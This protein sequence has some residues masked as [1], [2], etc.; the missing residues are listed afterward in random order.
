MKKVLCVCLA[1]V[2]LLGAIFIAPTTTRAASNMK[3]SEDCIAVIKELEG[4]RG[5]PYTDTDGLYTIGYGTR[6]PADKVDQYMQTPMTEA[7]ADLALREKLLSYESAVNKF[8]DRHGLTY[9][10][11]Q[12]DAVISLVFNCGTA[13]LTKGE[14]LVAALTSGA[15]GND[16]IYAFSIYSTSGG[17]R[18]VGH[19]KRRLAESNMYLNGQY[20]RTPP[21]NYSY[22]IYD[23]N[24][25]EVS[26][27]N[28]QGY[29]INTPVAVIPTATYAGY[30]FRGWYTARNGGTKVTVLDASTKAATL[31]AQWEK[32]DG[33]AA[34]PVDPKPSQP[35]EPTVPSGTAITPVEV[36]VTGSEVNIRKGP[37]LSYTVIDTMV[38]GDKVTVSATY[39][40]DNYL[41]GKFSNGWLCL[42]NTNYKNVSNP[43][44]QEPEK[45]PEKEPE[46]QPEK[47]PEK[48]PEQKPVTVTKTYATVTATSL[49][50]RKTP[51]G[52]WVGNYPNGTK[53]EIL[54]QKKASDGR[55][56]G[57]TSKGWICLTDYTK[58][59]TV[60]ETVTTPSTSATT[61]KIYAIV[62]N[63][64]ALNVRKTPNGTWCDSLKRGTRIEILEQ[65]IGS[66]GCNWGRTS[67]GWI[68]LTRYCTLETVTAGGTTTNTPN[69]NTNTNTNT[70]AGT[71]TY[72]TITAGL[73]NVRQTANGTW[74]GTVSRGTRL[75]V[76]EQQKIGSNTW[77]RTS[78]GWIC[79]TNYTK[80]ETVKDQSNSGTATKPAENPSSN[81]VTRTYAVITADVLNVRKTA[82]GTWIGTVT[83]GTRLEVL[84]QK[85]VGTNTW[86]RTSKGWICLTNYAKLETVSESAG[87]TTTTVKT[88]K[89]K[90]SCLNIRA[91]AGTQYGITGH[92]YNGQTVKIYEIKT[93]GSRKWGRVDKG[94]VC[95]D[96][97]V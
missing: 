49:N 29:D 55:T 6:C 37:G 43:S 72:A 46:K 94:W 9:R 35:A 71:K 79:L 16:L 39:E 83:R 57:R 67:K 59:S 14:T 36:T 38:R 80:L 78:K 48:Q 20:R 86:G 44:A 81:T 58:L 28:V 3:T 82:N 62:S 60:T 31:Y 51:A 68:C 87:N 30:T 73:L 8:I 92:Y 91:S 19:I 5:T 23:G 7:E 42:D 27:Y 69:T 89:V 18:S 61:T 96:Y 25:G 34:A 66:D 32:S 1:A 22:V 47:E 41:W 56:W 33:T 54:E 12:F 40:S 76:F 63:A 88:G 64:T 74:I 95:M 84:E 75:E 52:T 85:K 17:V 26:T 21:S 90:A 70:N 93:V 11:G 24:G 2:L 13:W 77:G 10:Q 65:K 50:I 45:Q 4:F 97:I 15:T 53:V